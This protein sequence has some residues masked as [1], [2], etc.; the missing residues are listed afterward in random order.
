M[1][2]KRRGRRTERGEG[3]TAERRRTRADKRGDRGGGR[4][5]DSDK[6]VE[7]VREEGGGG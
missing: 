6:E 7:E 2:A 5:M 4:R 3:G 1:T